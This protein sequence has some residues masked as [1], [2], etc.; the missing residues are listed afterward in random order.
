MSVVKITCASDFFVALMG[1]PFVNE[2]E[3]MKD[4]FI[5]NQNIKGLN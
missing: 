1:L 4:R 3:S 2:N 5:I